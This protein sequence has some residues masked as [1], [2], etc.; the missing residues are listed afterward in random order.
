[1]NLEPQKFFFEVPIY[2]RI[3]ITPD[4]WLEME[5]LVRFSGKV[6]GYNPA[7]EIDS[8]F[9]CIYNIG[10]NAINLQSW[11][12]FKMQL[13]C[14]RYGDRLTFFLKFEPKYELDED[15]DPER[16]EHYGTLTK[17]GQDPSIADFHV[18]KIKKFS[19]V[20][21]NEKQKELVKGIG[22]AAH[23][24]G[25]GSFVYLRRI[26]EDLIEE[27]HSLGSKEADWDEES[28]K[29]SRIK[30]RIEL[31][32]NHLPEFLVKNRAMYAVLSKGIHELTED[33]CLTY[34]ETVRLGI[35]EILEEKL[36]KLNKETRAK[37]AESKL[38]IL[39]KKVG[40][41]SN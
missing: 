29:K 41:S 27:A 39:I 32:Q 7:K 1:M 23:G 38:G 33:E 24:V 3:E 22:L 9:S 5:R 19:R 28:Y 8:T 40:E 16:V 35:E 17:I 18:D 25:I 26:F 21:G 36:E 31:L 37:E 11:G 12:I 10:D 15:G 14:L 34:F 30:E 2:E 6:E 4:N 13:L 20:L